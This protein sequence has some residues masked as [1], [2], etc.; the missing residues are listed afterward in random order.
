MPYTHFRYIAYQVPTVG[1]NGVNAIY[2][3]P[4]GNVNNPPTLVSVL[5]LSPDAKTRV[6]RLIGVIIEAE[7]QLR[8]LG[9]DNAHTLKIFMAPEF[10][11]RP[12]N[13]IVAY[14][15]DEYQAIK[16]A[17]RETIISNVKFKDWLVIPGTIMWVWDAFKDSPK[18]L[19]PE[20]DS[21]YFNT[22]IY[23]KRQGLGYESK[24]I[25]K[26]QA[27]RIDGIP[28]GRHYK[29]NPVPVGN[30]FAKST[31]EQW[32]KYQELSKLKKHEF[33]INGI[34]CGLEVCLEHGLS[35][36]PG[37]IGLLKSIPSITDDL[38]HFDLDLQLLTS[39]G[40]PI[41]I[42]S[43][44]ADVGGYIMRNDGY[45][46]NPKTNC[47]RILGYNPINNSANLAPNTIVER[48]VNL[49]GGNLFLNPPP[50]DVLW[51]NHPQEIKIY[52]RLQIR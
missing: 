11:F 52:Q 20:H 50:G 14:F 38:L 22:A 16:N 43:V 48:T 28:T 34:R 35:Y 32:T 26:A 39:G 19:N 5:G 45:S 25:E 21:I 9:G 10:Y 47:Q 15:Y 37:T 24:T 40:M 17:L 8:N 30:P 3:I 46:N 33:T 41:R 12:D 13:D 4:A 29:H 31:D 18:R 1:H 49:Q 7:N 6:E 36:A 2:G 27:S 51:P 23:I 42:D 44:A